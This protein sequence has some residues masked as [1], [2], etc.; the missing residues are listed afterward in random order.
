MITDDGK[1]LARR[2][3]PRTASYRGE[4]CVNPQSLGAG[5]LCTLTCRQPKQAMTASR[6]RKQV[7]VQL[8]VSHGLSNS[9][10]VLSY[11]DFG[12]LDW[13]PTHVRLLRERIKQCALAKAWVKK[14]GVALAFVADLVKFLAPRPHTLQAARPRHTH[15]NVM[16]IT[17]CSVKMLLSWL[18]RLLL[19]LLLP[20]IAQHEE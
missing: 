11:P 18:L 2:T 15:V 19:L 17:F 20:S 9:C 3:V 13:M 16:N 5:D 8:E 10:A 4:L 14:R 7:A 6:S 12:L 1:I